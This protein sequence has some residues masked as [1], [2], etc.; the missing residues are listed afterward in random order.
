MGTIAKAFAA[1]RS[2]ALRMCTHGQHCAVAN[3]SV[4]HQVHCG[5]SC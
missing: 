4:K 3:A 2:F 5:I 1:G